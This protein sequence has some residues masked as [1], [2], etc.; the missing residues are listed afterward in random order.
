MKRLRL[1]IVT[2]RYWPLVGDAEQMTARLADAFC[3]RGMDVTVL[4][5]RWHSDWPT[6]VMHRQTRVERLPYAPRGGWNTLRYMRALSRWIRTKRNDFDI[7]YV[8]NLKHDAYATVGAAA[9]LRL[10]VIL[11]ARRAGPTGDCH[12]QTTA[13]FGKRIRTRCQAA[14]AVVSSTPV[15][16]QELASAGYTS[17]MQICDG[18]EEAPPRSAAERFRARAALADINHD[19]AVAEYAPV[20]VCVE[21]LQ[22][23]RGLEKLIR[24]WFP[25]GE[26][27]PSAK[28]WI[29]GDGPLRDSLYEGIVDLG[30][31]HQI[32]LPG[33]F[34]DWH[35]LLQAADAYVSASPDFATTQ[36]LLDAMAA[37]LPILAN[38]TPDVHDVLESGVQGYLFET[39]DSSSLLD[40]VSRLSESPG[41]GIQVGLAARRRASEA[42]SITRT[43]DQH[44]QL[45]HRMA[46]KGSSKQS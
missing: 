25:V 24:A 8:M 46:S 4:T 18:T 1:L 44:E 30:L 14:V 38:D 43:V 16:A 23:G 15:G 21:R 13:R 22:E 37:G 41:L 2:P 5:A 10:P 19:L 32:L 29:I 28:L 42:F 33:S 7:V 9:S 6:M 35:E 11:R 20:A 36:A 17:V 39:S 45:F 3:S 26:R 12:W 31:H 40:A 34:D 27:W